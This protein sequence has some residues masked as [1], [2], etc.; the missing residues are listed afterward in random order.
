MD[1]RVVGE[2]GEGS[3]PFQVEVEEGELL[4]N[5]VMLVLLAAPIALVAAVWWWISSRPGKTVVP[6]PP[7]P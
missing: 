2:A 1:I 7:R 4:D 6:R 3:V 5:L